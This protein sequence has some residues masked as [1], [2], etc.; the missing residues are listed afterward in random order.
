MDFPFLSAS[1]IIL[2]FLPPNSLLCLGNSQTI[3]LFDSLTKQEIGYWQKKNFEVLSQRGLSGIEGHLHMGLGAYQ[4]K[5]HFHQAIAVFLG[6]ISFL[7]DNNFWSS[8]FFPSSFSI[9]LLYF[10]FNDQK[11]SIFEKVAPNLPTEALNLIETKHNHQL[12]ETFT[13]KG[14]E[15]QSL[16]LKISQDDFSVQVQSFLEKLISNPQM[17]LIEIG[18]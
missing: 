1:K 9:P 11:G 12:L 10:I 16:S 5:E 4:A 15:S 6:D 17:G 18:L 14:I 7:Y 3:R 13:L 2:D 8:N